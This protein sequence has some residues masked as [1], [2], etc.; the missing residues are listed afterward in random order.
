MLLTIARFELKSRLKLTSTY[1]YFG[2]FFALALLFIAAA[3][4]VFPGAQV[5]FGGG[6]QLINAPYALAQIIT[7]L[8]YLGLIVV[9]A[10]MGRAVQQDFEYRCQHFF[11]SLPISKTQYLVGRFLGAYACL[12]LIFLSLGLGAFVGTLLPGIDP[13]RLGA[14]SFQAYAMPFVLSLWPNLF[15]LGALFFGI[16][17]LTRRMM[18]V[19]VSSV[20]LL[21]GYLVAGNLLA[22]MENKTLGALL[23]PVGANALAVL[24]RYWTLSERNVLQVPLEGVFLWNRL[25]WLGLGLAFAGFCWHR[26]RFASG[27][28][29]AGKAAAVV[30][31]PAASKPALPQV[32][33]RHEGLGLRLLPSLVALSLRET[34]K[35]IYFLVIVLAGVLFM[36]ANAPV[37]GTMFGTTTYPVTYEV[38]EV[39]GGSFAL[40]MLIITTFYAGELVWRER[41]A[42]MNQIYDA[43]PI[44]S[45]LPLAAKL[46][47]LMGV[48]ALLMFVIMACGM[49]IQAFKGYFQFEPGLYLHWLF[50]ISLI[51]YWLLAVLAVA[52]QV[53]VNNKYLGHFLMILYYVGVSSAA[54]MGFEHRMYVYG[55]MPTMTYSDMNGFG[56][57]MAGVRWF[58]AYWGFAALLLAVAARLFWVRGTASSWRERLGAARAQLSRPVLA[59]ACAGLAGFVAV[60]AYVFYN[61]NVLNSYETSYDQEALAAA[62]E[63]TY[64]P[65]KDKA[66]PL[67]VDVRLNVDIFPEARAARIKGHYQLKN[68]SQEAI[69]EL[70]LNL[71]TEA[72]LHVLRPSTAHKPGAMD[73]VQGLHCMI[74][75]QPLLP[76]ASLGLDFELE[77]ANEGFKN[78]EGASSLA[79]NGNGS[80]FN[81]SLLPSL[82]YVE[83]RELV[84]D[85][86]RRK[87]DLAPKERMPDLDDP[88]GRMANLAGDSNWIGFE[89][90]VSTSADQIAL[91]PGYLQKEW[92]ENGRRYFH[93]KMDRPILNFYAFLSARYAVKRD[94]WN[95]VAIEIYY[96]PGHEYNLERM[97]AGVKDSLDYFSKHFGPYQHKQ[98]RILEF[99]RYAS[100]AQSFPNTIPYSES[101]GFIAKV[102]PE[103]KEDLDYPYYIT[104]HEVAH[105]WWGHQVVG[106][107]V[108]GETFLAESMAQYSALMVMKQKYGADKMARF[109]RYELDRY[110]SARG[111]E[112]KKEMPLMRVENQPYI[113]YQKG[114]LVMYALQDYLGEAEVNRVL[115]E[116]VKKVAFQAP[117]FTHARELVD[118]FRKLA[119]EHLRYVIADSFEHIVLY[120]NRALSADYRQRED[121]KYELT[122]KVAARKFRADAQGVEQ[123]APMADYI[124]IGVLDDQDKP[125]LLERRKLAAGESEFTLVVDKLPAKA[126]ID[127][128]NK[129]VDRRIEDNVVAVSKRG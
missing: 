41:D 28:E 103:D 106:G 13:Q 9:A 52:V 120:E 36:F 89:A 108:Q 115:G 51:D 71:P 46:L 40:F 91:A 76:G 62:Y 50:G 73:L 94:R 64:K 122:L 86:V 57:F 19:Y 112:Q 38:L 43:L 12:L 116:Y 11:F 68:Q 82:G 25:L 2:M 119:P 20:V 4:G 6:K 117:P 44:P 129:L 67:V 66:Q 61:T 54:L 127:P 110:L 109:L 37:I 70:Y 60:G 47:A 72:Q 18:P 8:G 92:T 29:K 15:F 80:F 26:F 121:G 16:A 33:P 97:V 78:Q 49:L 111:G 56:H 99:P 79:F 87:H 39:A 63:K 22:D 75:D 95:D 100:F 83:R 98:V 53:L 74:L 113:H 88:Q 90:T 34:V 5:R 17:A 118:E 96:H 105:Q 124:D 58:E 48:Q 102:D 59:T 81:N 123:E 35:N 126:G 30:E 114:S 65:L 31:T 7:T 107:A 93:Y 45:W 27:D 125:L 128:M 84:D 23:D 24:T 77:Y 1:V 101:I 10:M 21:I 85:R 69:K 104:A 32:Q 55:S 3:G 42:R 14:S